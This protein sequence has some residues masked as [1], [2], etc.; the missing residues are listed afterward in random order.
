MDPART[1]ALLILD[2]GSRLMPYKD[3]V[4]HLTIGIGHNL[5]ANGI[6][7]AVQDQLYR[8]D[9][10]HAQHVLNLFAPLWQTWDDV[11]QAA[12]LSLAFN[13]GSRLFAFTTLRTALQG[14]NWA[15]AGQSL[16]DSL[17]YQQVG[18]R[19]PRLVSMFV[20]GQWPDGVA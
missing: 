1:K 20:T 3:S 6:S 15:L 18:D 16:K 9:M 13:L 19:G 4:G 7:A 8:E 11:R 12:G 5:D 2:E 17:W 14:Q 10:D